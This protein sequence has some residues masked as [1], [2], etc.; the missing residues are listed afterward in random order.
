MTGWVIGAIKLIIISVAL[1]VVLLC[2]AI[3]FA[4]YANDIDLAT[5]IGYGL[6]ILTMILH[7]ALTRKEKGDQW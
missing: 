7:D 4:R 5:L 1:P 6:G 2:I 3:A